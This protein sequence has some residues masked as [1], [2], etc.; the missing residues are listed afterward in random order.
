MSLHADRGAPMRS[1]TVAMLLAQ[2][3]ITASFSRPYTSD[4]N[5][6]SE[7]QF[8][9]LK[10]WPGFPDRFGGQEDVEEFCRPFF[11]WYNTEHRHSGIGL[12][13]AHLN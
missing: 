7:A 11:R 2:L 12:S 5:P 10:Y 13:L 3:G 9:T 6:Y 4:D 1:K 8:K